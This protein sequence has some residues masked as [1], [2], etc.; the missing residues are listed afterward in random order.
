MPASVYHPNQPVLRQSTINPYS[1]QPKD[2]EAITQRRVPMNPQS[3][4]G[5]RPPYKADEFV[6]R[7]ALVSE[8]NERAQRL[9]NGEWL[10]ANQRI[11]VLTGE[12]GIGKTWLLKHLHQQFSQ[13][14]SKQLL[15]HWFDLPNRNRLPEDYDA[16]RMLIQILLTFAETLLGNAVV[17][18]ITNITLPDLSRQII[19]QLRSRLQSHYLAIFLD[20]VFEA[21][22]SFLELFEEHLLGPLAIEKKVLVIM[23]GRGR[24]FPWATPEL[25]FEAD[26]RSLEPFTVDETRSQLQAQQ[27]RAAQQADQ[28]RQTSG[29][30]PLINFLL[31]QG[32]KLDRVI[33]EILSMIAGGDYRTMRQNLEALCVLQAFDD[34]RIQQMITAYRAIGNKGNSF[35]ALSLSQS[36]EIRRALVH[37]ALVHYDKKQGAYVLDKHLRRLLEEHL[38]LHENRLVWCHLHKTAHAL[39]KEWQGKYTRNQQHWQAEMDYHAEHLTAGNCI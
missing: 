26:L 6:G 14:F 19:E 35:G 23:A 31:G 27:P 10:P 16:T 29:G 5:L 36:V 33:N 9:C 2:P 34:D 13:Q 28:I 39:Y 38:R 20:E 32:T 8:F 7:G 37:E 18:R 17:Q 30:V 24:I 1:G 25:R 11:I 21:D 12:V 15:L 3:I 4:A 22:W